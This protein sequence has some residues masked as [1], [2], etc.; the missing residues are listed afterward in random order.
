MG[1]GKIYDN[2]NFSSLVS[3]DA[4]TMFRKLQKLVNCHKNQSQ[5]HVFS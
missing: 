4:L 5:H 1:R 2:D 3:V